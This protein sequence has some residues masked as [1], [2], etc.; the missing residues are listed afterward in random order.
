[1]ADDLDRLVE[2]VR[3]G[4][5]YQAVSIELVRRV[6][7]QELAKGLRLKEAVKATRNK[8]HQVG[9][10][11]QE[12]GIPYAAWRRELS[13]LPRDLHSPAVMDFCRL[14]MAAHAS[15]R[16][17]LPVLEQFYNQALAGLPPL[18]SLLDA[19]CGLNPLALPWMPLAP[20]AAYFACDIYQ[21]MV[22][23][24]NAF[25]EHMQVNGEAVVCDLTAEIPT[26]PAQLAL[27]LKTLPCLEQLDKSIGPRLLDGLNV[28]WLLVTFPA[29]SL[30][31]RS[32]G[33]PEFYE[34]HFR[35]LVAPRGWQLAS[36]EFASEL[37]FR[38]EKG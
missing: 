13:G 2:A 23:F 12:G 25:F 38:V 15:T 26:R 32:K 31:G 17:R 7:A 22:D 16:E 9:G 8:I 37:A 27:V 4:A 6:G 21:D 20:G 36:F 19:A 34:A 33:M 30:G 3:A 5:K 35:E 1:M 11:Y 10:A 24:L 29:R 14:A 18:E 28:D